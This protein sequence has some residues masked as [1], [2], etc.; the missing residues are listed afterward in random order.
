MEVVGDR[1]TRSGAIG[2]TN[3]LEDF[4]DFD[5]GPHA[6]NGDPLETFTPYF[7]TSDELM[8]FLR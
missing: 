4:M 2:L 8:H 6:I 5:I 3:S 7:E 1:Q